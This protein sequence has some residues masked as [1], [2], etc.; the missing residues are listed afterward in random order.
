MK[1][2]WNEVD[3][4]KQVVELDSRGEVKHIG[5]NHKLFVMRIILSKNN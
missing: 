4:E 3:G 1:G 2:D 5:R